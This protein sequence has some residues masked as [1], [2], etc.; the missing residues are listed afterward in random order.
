L[1]RFRRLEDCNYI[2]IWK[3]KSSL[4]SIQEHRD[5]SLF[6]HHFDYGSRYGFDKSEWFGESL[7]IKSAEELQEL[8]HVET[9]HYGQRRALS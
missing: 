1:P 3:L 7:P 4:C 5:P 2:T 9:R 6:D 8:Q